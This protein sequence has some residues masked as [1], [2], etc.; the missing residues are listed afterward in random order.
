MV[1]RWDCGC[2]GPQRNRFSK[3]FCLQ[4]FGFGHYTVFFRFKKLK[5]TRKHV[6]ALKIP[7]LFPFC[8]I[9]AKKTLPLRFDCYSHLTTN[10][11]LEKHCLVVLAVEVLTFLKATHTLFRAKFE[12][13]YHLPGE[14]LPKIKLDE[15]RGRRGRDSPLFRPSFLLSGSFQVQV[16]KK[17]SPV[18]KKPSNS[19]GISDDPPSPARRTEVFLL[20][21]SFFS[22]A[23]SE[24]STFIKNIRFWWD[25][26]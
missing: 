26:G 20:F 25:I 2:V 13:F 21:M 23:S 8:S 18:I 22:E 7:C 16:L 1:L 9:Y 5:N 14:I 10:G 3:R 15:G 12:I 4:P 6:F 19:G 24:K 17:S 11:N